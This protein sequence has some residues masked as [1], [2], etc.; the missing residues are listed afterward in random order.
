M[1]DSY[2]YGDRGPQIVE[3]Q[4]ALAAS[5]IPMPAHGSCG[6]MVGETWAALGIWCDA[7]GVPWDA[8]TW[9][10]SAAIVDAIIEAENPPAPS[11]PRPEPVAKPVAPVKKAKRK[12]KRGH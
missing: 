4:D 7:Q 8:Q 1:V 10:V 11:V 5:G 6:V 2:K 3:L 9:K 12:K